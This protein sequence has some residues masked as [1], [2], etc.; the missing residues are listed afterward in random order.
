M[1]QFFG[2][3]TSYCGGSA[4]NLHERRENMRKWAQIPTDK[5]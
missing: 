1:N 3:W 5:Y 2:T 4:G